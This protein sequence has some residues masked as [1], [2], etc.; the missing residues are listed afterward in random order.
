MKFNATGDRK[1]GN[2]LLRVKTETELSFV[3]KFFHADI[4][5]F[6]RYNPTESR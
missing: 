6:T 4:R 1:K 3:K 2:F 5:P